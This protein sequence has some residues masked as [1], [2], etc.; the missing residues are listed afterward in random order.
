MTDESERSGE[1]WG[2]DCRG[3]RVCTTKI[4][5]CV[6]VIR[7]GHAVG[8][9][10]EVSI[11]FFGKV[12]LLVKASA[13]ASIV[14]YCKQGR[15]RAVLCT[16][17][18]GDAEA[19]ASQSPTGRITGRISQDPDRPTGVSMKNFAWLALGSSPAPLLSRFP[20]SPGKKSG[21]PPSSFFLT[22]GN[23]E[24][25]REKQHK[26]N[27]PS[28]LI[29]DYLDF[30]EQAYQ[31]YSKRAGGT[32]CSAIGMS[33]GSVPHANSS[34]QYNRSAWRTV[35]AGRG[36][37]SNFFSCRIWGLSQPPSSR[38]HSPA[39]VWRICFWPWKPQT[40]TGM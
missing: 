22:S 28:V 15:R 19:S 14:S 10:V 3:G 40:W 35:Y 37:P 1:I 36:K 11:R 24:Y 6:H 2:V 26:F 23:R 39:V 5:R 17:R 18:S 38:S 29:S 9:K 32:P 7:R 31:V 4:V 8:G 33:Q 27:Q 12:H 34:L 16:S 20:G 25:P 13:V 30:F 21:R